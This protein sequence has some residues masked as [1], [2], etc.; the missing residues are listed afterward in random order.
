MFHLLHPGEHEY[1][2][3]QVL[4]STAC[5]RAAKLRGPLLLLLLLLLLLCKALERLT[6]TTVEQLCT[7]IPH[8]CLHAN[9]LQALHQM[10]AADNSGDGKL[11]LSEMVSNPYVFYGSSGA[12]AF[13]D[14]HASIDWYLPGPIASS[15]CLIHNC[16]VT[17]WQN[18]KA[19]T[20][21]PAC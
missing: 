2:R 4:F 12:I 14:C 13:N 1:A 10:T 16:L 3:M 20:C 17:P 15:C 11:T 9:N 6:S 19:S 8:E 5:R 7:G 21:P 18:G